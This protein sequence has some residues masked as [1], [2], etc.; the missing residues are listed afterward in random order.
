M[1]PLIMWLHVCHT[2]YYPWHCGLELVIF[3][4]L[5]YNSAGGGGGTGSTHYSGMASTVCHCMKYMCKL[6]VLS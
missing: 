1:N 2:V 5:E 4:M 3:I 6:H